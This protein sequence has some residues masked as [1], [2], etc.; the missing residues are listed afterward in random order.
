MFNIPEPTSKE[1]IESSNLNVL[2]LPLLAFDNK[3]FR[4][5]YGKGFYDKYL[6]RSSMDLV[7]IGV[8]LFEDPIEI[9]DVNEFDIKMDYCVTPNQIFKF[10]N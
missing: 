10:K 2:L 7:K 6:N 9:D 5:G 4:V 3:G 1:K 8:S